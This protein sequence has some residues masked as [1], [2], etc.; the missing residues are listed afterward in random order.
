WRAIAKAISFG[1]LYSMGIK[2]LGETI[3]VSRDQA[4]I[5]FDAYMRAFPTVRVFMNRITEVAD[6]RGYIR[7]A[8]NRRVRFRRITDAERAAGK[9]KI[10]KGWMQIWGNMQNYVTHKALN[11]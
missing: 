7:T 3:G 4:K 8:F 10:S 9:I 1:V 11:H 6:Q 2:K 5:Y